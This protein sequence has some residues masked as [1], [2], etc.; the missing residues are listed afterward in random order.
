LAVLAGT[1]SAS[2]ISSSERPSQGAQPQRRALAFGQ[3]RERGDDAAE[4]DRA[5]HARLRL[6][7][8]GGGHVGVQRERLALAA[9]HVER[10]PP[11]DRRQPGAHVARRG[12]ADQ[13]P[14]RGEQRLLHGVLGELGR[15][16]PPD[17]A[18]QRV[19]VAI[20]ELGEG[21]LVARARARGKP[22]VLI[23]ITAHPGDRRRK[24]GK[25]SHVLKAVEGAT[26][27]VA[28]SDVKGMRIPI[29]TAIAV[30]SLSG[31]ALAAGGAGSI[32][33]QP[34]PEA[35]LNRPVSVDVSI[36][37]DAGATV[38]TLTCDWATGG[39]G[40]D[41]S[42]CLKFQSDP[43]VAFGSIEQAGGVRA[44]Q[45]TTTDVSDMRIAYSR[46]G[47]G[48]WLIRSHGT[49]DGREMH[50]G[51]VCTADGQSCV[52]W[53]ADGGRYARKDVRAAASKL[54]RRR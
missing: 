27:G 10:P 29:L 30:L 15:E 31:T 42:A 4:L 17:V 2:P 5:D 36:L 23:S 47:D 24:T 12:P 3:L 19:A 1:S 48:T 53:D 43:Q 50:F 38:K 51:R 35:E 46:R 45:H 9:R 37:D 39:P 40:E 22:P 26:P 11:G 7:R 18:Q 6:L 21:P 49:V 25:V 20:D 32:G 33:I 54:K 14:V 41:D 8:G 13:R 44:D 28:V 34:V 52:R 16:A